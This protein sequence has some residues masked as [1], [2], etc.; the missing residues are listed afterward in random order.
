MKKLVSMLLFHAQVAIL[1][2]VAFTD[3]KVFRSTLIAVNTFLVLITMKVVRM[4]CFLL[5]S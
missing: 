4:M 1:K 3:E 5:A 2:F